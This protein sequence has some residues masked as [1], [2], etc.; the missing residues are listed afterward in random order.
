MIKESMACHSFPA[1]VVVVV[2]VSCLLA[3]PAVTAS[4]VN[5]STYWGTNSVE[6]GIEDACKTDLYSIV[7]IGFVYKFGNGQTP[8]LKLSGH[9]CDPSV[10][11]CTYLGGE[12]RYCQQMG[13][14]VLISIGGPTGDYNLTSQDDV[15]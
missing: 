5:I 6:G 7:N 14:K 15:T 1:V 12:I 3:P 8:V 2:L 13:I 10:Q 9:P 11:G 4:S